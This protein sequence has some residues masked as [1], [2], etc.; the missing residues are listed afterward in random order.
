MI[1]SSI[2]D[3]ILSYQELDK[4]IDVVYAEHIQTS[5]RSYGIVPR[6]IYQRSGES[7]IQGIFRD[8]SIVLVDKN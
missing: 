5:C 3:K 7:F 1:H 4:Q 6:M 8:Y 2:Y